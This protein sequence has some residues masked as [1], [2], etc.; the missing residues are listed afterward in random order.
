MPR[1]NRAIELLEQGQPIYYITI[2]DE[3]RNFEGGVRAAGTWADYISYDVEHA[4]FDM[5][6]LSEF[7][8][9]MVAAG[10][11]R[12]GHRTPAVIVSTPMS[13]TDEMTVRANAWQLQQILATG[14]H[15]V[16]LAH[17]ESLAAARAFVECCRYP[18]NRIGV[19]EGLGEGRR[20][21]GG[22]RSA[23]AIWGVSIREYLDFADAW[24][25]NPKGELM[26][27]LKIEDKRGL[28][29]VESSLKAPGISFVEWGPGDMGK[30]MGFPDN[31]N[32]PHPPE[33]T[34][35]RTRIFAAVKANNLFFLNS[36]YPHNVAERIE[37]G[38]MIGFGGV[39][40][41]EAAEVGRKYTK[42]TMPW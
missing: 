1:I 4:P 2:P 14:V 16:L 29:N 8:R 37:E 3:E 7:M 22:Q 42:R 9:G 21:D 25:L 5:T 35:A 34:A 31:H 26:L 38:V 40:G 23:S 27:G 18:F 17:V 24:P 33:M 15:G 32:E 36:V 41:Q 10:P 11:T 28:A 30:S 19:D 39:A 20:G 12:S 6:R 13:G